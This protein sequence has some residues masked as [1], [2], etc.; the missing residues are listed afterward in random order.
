MRREI[1]TEAAF[2]TAH[3]ASILAQGVSASLHTLESLRG[4]DGNFT[5]RLRWGKYSTATETAVW[6]QSSNP[7]NVS[8]VTG[9]N[10]VEVPTWQAAA[11]TDRWRGAG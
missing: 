8:V 3:F 10:A 7:T 4:A 2:N 11:G 9:Y 1:H 5:F 6:R